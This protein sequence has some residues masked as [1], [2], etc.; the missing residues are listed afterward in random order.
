MSKTH[1]GAA[2]CAASAPSS[3]TRRS[4][5]KG[6]AAAAIAAGACGLVA[7]TSAADN[8]F[9]DE[10]ATP[11]PVEEEIYPGTCSGFC[12]GG[13]SYNLHVRDGKLVRVSVREMADPAY[14]RVCQKGY[15]QP[16]RVYNPARL[17]KPLRRVGEKGSGEWEE[18]TWDEAISEICEKWTA[19]TDEYGPGAM[20]TTAI[21]GSFDFIGG[22]AATSIY[23]R[24]KKAT[25]MTSVASNVDG[26]T[27]Y[28]CNRMMGQDLFNT[29]NEPKDLANAKTIFIWGASPTISEM[30]IVHFITEARLNGATIV[31]IDPLYTA[32]ASISDKYVPIKAS[33]DGA[34]A[35]G[36]MNEVLANGWEDREFL[37][38]STVAP[39]LVKPDTH[40][41]LRL[42]DLGLAE[43]D[44]EEDAIVVT[45][46][47]G[48]FDIPENIAT[49]VIEGTFDIN[50]M[51]VTCA[52]S[53]LLDRIAE[54]PVSRAA[55][56]TGIPEEE[57]KELTRLYAQETPSTIFTV[58]GADHYVNG[59]W[60]Y[61]AMVALVLLTGNIGKHG[62]GI[63]VPNT[64]KQNLL[65]MKFAGDV[66]CPVENT[67]TLQLI[68]ME[69]AIL[70]HTYNDEPFDL[71]GM[72]IAY[73]NPI[74]NAADRNRTIEAFK[75]LDLLVV[76]D[77]VMSETAEYAD[78][79]LP[80]THWFEREQLMATMV[81]HP[82]ITY[83]AAALP[84][85][86]DSLPD[87]E[88]IKLLADGL[89]I[90]EYFQYTQE[91]WAR[92]ILDTDEAREAGLTYETL[93]DIG[94]FRRVP[95]DEPFVFAADGVFPTATKRAAF[96]LEDPKPSNDYKPAFD[97]EKEYLPYWEEPLEVGEHS[98]AR[99]KY[100]F[101]LI[102]EHSRFRTHTQWGRVDAL[103]EVDSEQWLYIGPEDAE[104][105]GINDGDEVRVYNDRGEFITHARVRPNNPPGILS[106]A[107]G[108]R[109]DQ[110]LGGHLSNLSTK[111]SNSFCANQPFN[112]CAVAIEKA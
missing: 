62:A 96:Y 47:N 55:E 36:M 64:G 98:P 7:S 110:V 97:F 90:G 112:D 103:M 49:P 6:S 11:A 51:Q 30:Q 85:L 74:P 100:P 50:G 107:K 63:G 48:T 38:K 32:N 71:R 44:S 91:E 102:S 78:Y 57:I 105:L 46:G 18:I 69:S 77:M 59:H 87:F 12:N 72:Y 65:D 80:C 106:A 15:T 111:Q 61:T 28:V 92:M 24:F 22:N 37:S 95:G 45:D 88:I 21:T 27:K 52:Y 2:V 60:N 5:L 73:V 23:T 41:F 109:A 3:F 14:N 40:K 58:F 42:S 104:A 67:K 9:A 8:A 39:F 83:S 84:P 13:C 101:Q 16:F 99:E 35:F 66:P 19:I 26:A 108:W 76:V 68:N 75:A 1:D 56:V 4:F 10:E 25:G 17:T 53:L 89:G 54:W 31:N 43:A 33:T 86:G 94:S 20:G 81:M 82:C 79:V 34:L 70:D 93:T 29:A